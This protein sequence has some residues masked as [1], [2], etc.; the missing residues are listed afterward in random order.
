[1]NAAG[2]ACISYY[3]Q[4]IS[5]SLTADNLVTFSV[6]FYLYVCMHICIYLFTLLVRFNER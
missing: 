2:G 6:M 5:D 1:M 4:K 3:L